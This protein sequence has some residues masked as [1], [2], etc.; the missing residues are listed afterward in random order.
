PNDPD[1]WRTQ[2]LLL[3][4]S[5]KV[6]AVD[7]ATTQ[8]VD[9]TKIWNL[10]QSPQVYY[11]EGGLWQSVDEVYLNIPGF[12]ETHLSGYTGP[13]SYNGTADYTYKGFWL[14]WKFFWQGRFDFAN[15]AYGNIKALEYRDADA[16]ISN[17][18]LPNMRLD[19]DLCQSG[20]F[21]TPSQTVNEINSIGSVRP[22]VTPLSDVLQG[23]PWSVY[24][25]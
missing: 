19:P 20:R 5:E 21:L 3:T 11:G 12:N 22:I 6:L 17:I 15:G 4:H 10:T 9:I 13:P 18:L 7:A 23:A 1:V 25:K 24:E 2:H 16:R 14:Y 8:A